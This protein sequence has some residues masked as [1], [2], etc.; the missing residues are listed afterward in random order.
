MLTVVSAITSNLIVACL[1]AT[2]AVFVGRRTQSAWLAHL[3]WMS[4]FIKLV[5]PPLLM[6]PVPV[7]YFLASSGGTQSSFLPSVNRMLGYSE[8]LGRSGRFPDGS[9][10]R[11]AA[12]DSHL[13]LGTRLLQV[14]LVIMLA[15]AIYLLVRGIAR[16]SVFCRLLRQEGRIDE[17]ATDVVAELLAQKEF[18]RSRGRYSHR[19]C[20]RLIEARISPMLFGL[21]P[22]S[23]IVCPNRLWLELSLEQRRAFLAHEVAH[24]LRRDH[25]VRWIEWII[26]AVYW[27]FPLVYFARRQLERHEEVA[28][29]H[30]VIDRMKICRRTYAETL[31]SVV[32]FISDHHA[33]HPRLASRMQPTDLLEERLKCIMR[34]GTEGCISMPWCKACLIGCVAL[35]VMHPVSHRVHANFWV[36]HSSSSL[37]PRALVP[38]APTENFAAAASPKSIDVPERE[39]LP[40]VPLGWWTPPKPMGWQSSRFGE[41][42]YR[43]VTDENHRFVLEDEQDIPHD[44]GR[45]TVT[46]MASYV[47]PNR[48]LIADEVGEIHLWDMADS[49]SVSLIGRH[50]ARVSSIGF[51]PI[52]GLVS[53][54]S[55][56]NLFHWDVQSGQIKHSL[57]L[58]SETCSV[59][60]SLDGEF[61]AVVLGRWNGFSPTSQVYFLD[62]HRFE[63]QSVE[64]LNRQ[65]AVCQ[66][67]PKLGW[68]AV[69]WAGELI[70]LT[71]GTV[72][73]MPKREV[74]G[75]VVCQ[76][77]FENVG[78]KPEF[79]GESADE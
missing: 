45:H 13:D 27:W 40:N 69:D 54:D 63:V 29:D 51:H 59:R 56:G 79:Q 39:P 52:G 33:G 35:V 30:W 10:G 42:N 74:S 18:G 50:P 6:V 7:P 71:K 1:L 12:L 68:I 37:K 75:I 21:G 55:R 19:L 16:Y 20:V 73:I 44:F 48:L 58:G 17:E 78:Q 15:G 8:S 66:E 49:Q 64:R 76:D 60:W 24:Y 26:T 36:P 2:V 72:G 11:T 47:T 23:C 77:L 28:C 34:R 22:F 5:T 25:W 61:I 65:I 31:L 62:S 41:L 4:V 67:H 43:I 3:I 14:A 53:G 46:A 32:D 57:N 70:S 38:S 9:V